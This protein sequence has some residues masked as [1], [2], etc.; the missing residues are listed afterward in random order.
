MSDYIVSKSKIIDRKKDVVKKVAR[1]KLVRTKAGT[2]KSV[3][4]KVVRTKAVGTKVKR[5]KVVRAKVVR[6]KVVRSKVVRTKVVAPRIG[7]LKA[8]TISSSGKRFLSAFQLSRSDTLVSFSLQPGL[9]NKRSSIREILK[10]ELFYR[11][12]RNSKAFSFTAKLLNSI[13]LSRFGLSLKD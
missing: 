4:T 7:N 11:E 8:P 1:A 2:T 12:K 6:T 9:K 3:G 13:S 10:S 5:T